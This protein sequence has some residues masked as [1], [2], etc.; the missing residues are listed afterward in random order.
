[1]AEG[2]VDDGADG[3]GEVEGAFVGEHG[4]DEALGGIAG[5]EVV[6]EALGFFAEDEVV[7][8]LEVGVP[9]GGGG[10]GGEEP[11]AAGLDL[12]EVGVEVRVLGGGEAGPVVEAGAAAGFGGGVEAEGLDEVERGAGGDAGAADVAG[13]VGDLGLVEG[14][15]EVRGRHGGR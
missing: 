5:E 15:V 10:L 7:A 12:G 11:Q 1:L 2:L 4:E 14:D 13:V 6:G 3:G 8:E 9:D